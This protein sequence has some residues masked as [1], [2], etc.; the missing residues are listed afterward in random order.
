MPAYEVNGTRYEFPDNY[1]DEQVQQILTRQ[2]VIQA[3]K[4]QDPGVM[5]GLYE[6][7]LGPMVDLAAGAVS[8][9]L[10][11]ARGVATGLQSAAL[12]EPWKYAQKTGQAM[13]AGKPMDALRYAPGMVPVFGPAVEGITDTAE[14][15]QP[16]R[17]AGQTAGL[18]GSIVAP[19][20]VAKY[21]APLKAGAKTAITEI[22]GAPTGA[23]ASSMRQALEHSTP[24]LVNAMR[25]GLT[26]MDLVGAF[27]EALENAKAA[28]SAEYQAKLKA[29]PTDT[30][31][32]SI[33]PV[34]NTLAT[35]LNNYNIRITPKGALDFSRS[36]IS[37]PAAQAEVQGIF[38]DVTGWGS[39]SGDLTATGVD[40]LKR[41]IGNRYSQSSPVRAITR[42]TGDAAR[43]VLNQGVPGY[44]D[45]T[46]GYAKASRFLEQVKDLSL[47]SKNDGTAVR[48][49]TTLLNQNNGY[50]QMLAQRLSQFTPKDLEGMLAGQN[51]SRWSP[52]G[53]ARAGT[54]VG[55]AYQVA[56]HALNPYVAVGMA[57][58]SPRIMGE[59]MT[60][61]SKAPAVPEGVGKAI[62]YGAPAA[63]AV[64]IGGLLSGPQGMNG[65]LLGQ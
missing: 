8:H 35:Q 19:G 52:R 46:Q 36:T 55:L 7:T 65:G 61:L 51:L 30:A 16:M 37:D 20:A 60:L 62:Q 2:G 43:E 63:S 22:A 26:D 29:L 54:G 64:G 11:T 28:R 15:G 32:L 40:T 56:T 34:R 31:P 6:S 14:S 33:D 13:M 18:L 38:K 27:R 57:M 4:P 47:E 45:M 3:P 9:P 24:E 17:A 41:R 49:L 23:G 25:G 50:R 53:I 39:Q 44:Q 59:L 58:T 1:T 48:K 42:N 5:Q 10:D 21:A 12:T